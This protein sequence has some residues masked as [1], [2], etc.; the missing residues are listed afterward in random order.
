MET[1]PTDTD[2]KEKPNWILSKV[3]LQYE[4][5]DM[6]DD[7]NFGLALKSSMQGQGLL[8]PRDL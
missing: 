6:N 5:V 3:S 2:L 8:V 4:V 1:R 7:D